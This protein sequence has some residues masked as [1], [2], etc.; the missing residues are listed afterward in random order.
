MEIPDEVIDDVRRRLHRV[1]GQ[2]RAIERM[3]DDGRE[4]RDL[5]TQVSAATKA[6]EQVGF[7][8]LA[9][10][11]TYCVANPEAAAADGYSLEEV[12]KMFMKLA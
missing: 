11:L 1:A 3:L 5:V 4:C 12:Q 8:V 6:L 10:G 7:K 2:V 9:S